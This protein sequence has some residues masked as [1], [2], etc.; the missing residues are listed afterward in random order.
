[1]S[2]DNHSHINDVSEIKSSWGNVSRG[3]SILGGVVA[4]F[5]GLSL[6]TLRAQDS[7]S[8]IES[9]A[10]GM[11]YYFIGKGIFMIAMTLNFQDALRLVR[12]R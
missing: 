1:M 7:D 9:I 3:F 11:G 4:I 2:N 6:A 8:M 5:A 10:N 12:I